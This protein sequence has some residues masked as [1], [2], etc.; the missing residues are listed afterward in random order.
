MLTLKLARSFGNKLPLTLSRISR[1][2]ALPRRILML[3]ARGLENLARRIGVEQH[4][5]GADNQIGSA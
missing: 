5:A 2:F 3:F 4:D 1:F